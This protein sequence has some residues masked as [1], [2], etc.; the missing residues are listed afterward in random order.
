ME[1][2]IKILSIYTILASLYS[3]VTRIMTIGK[4]MKLTILGTTISVILV[5]PIFVLGVLVF[6]YLN[7]K[8]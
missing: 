8:I 6:L 5:V 1:K 3:I 2:A 4:I 7:R